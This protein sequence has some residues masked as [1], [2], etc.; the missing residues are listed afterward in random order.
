MV[1]E[2]MIPLPADTAMQIVIVLVFSYL[3]KIPWMKI[4]MRSSLVADEI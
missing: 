3:L 4:G 2:G 1:K